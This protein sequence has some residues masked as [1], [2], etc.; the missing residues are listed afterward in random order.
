MRLLLFTGGF[1]LKKSLAI[2]PNLLLK[3][4]LRVA[5]KSFESI[6]LKFYFGQNV[7]L[8]NNILHLKASHIP[9]CVLLL[10]PISADWEI[11]LCFRDAKEP[12]LQLCWGRDEAQPR[13]VNTV[14]KM[15][16]LM[17]ILADQIK[18]KT[19]QWFYLQLE[20]VPDE[21]LLTRPCGSENPEPESHCRCPAIL[22]VST[23]SH[24]LAFMFKR[25]FKFMYSV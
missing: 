23:L 10:S 25:D 15:N 16:I 21:W 12:Y 3:T 24:P 8:N 19:R 4:R 2:A 17:T 18:N 1:V 13:W 20:S 14:T 5:V 9:M 6:K 22:Y 7:F 11:V